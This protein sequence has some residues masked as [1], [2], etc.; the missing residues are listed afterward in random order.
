[1]TITAGDNKNKF[2]NHSLPPCLGRC[3][4]SRLP[5]RSA[6]LSLQLRGV[7][8]T[9]APPAR[10]QAPWTRGAVPALAIRGACPHWAVRGGRC[11]SLRSALEPNIH[12][13]RSLLY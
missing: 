10:E 13:S 7:H 6:L 5:A 2:I 3:P 1:M 4:M 11:A 8:R 9:P 12:Y